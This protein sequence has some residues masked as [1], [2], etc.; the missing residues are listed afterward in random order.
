MVKE[1]SKSHKLSTL[2][3]ITFFEQSSY[4]IM[5]FSGKFVYIDDVFSGFYILNSFYL[6]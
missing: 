3:T 6:N 4:K 5:F 1:N 2:N